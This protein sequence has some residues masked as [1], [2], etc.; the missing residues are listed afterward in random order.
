MNTRR[1]SIKATQFAKPYVYVK[2]LSE[3][4]I[5]LIY[6]NCV[7]NL[8][9]HRYLNLMGFTSTDIREYCKGD[10]DESLVSRIENALKKYQVPNEDFVSE[11][12]GYKIILFWAGETALIS[13]KKSPFMTN[14]AIKLGRS[15]NIYLNPNKKGR[16][17]AYAIPESWWHIKP[18]TDHVA[19]LIK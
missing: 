14:S 8:S 17:R 5:D 19:T 2:D 11:F 12:D 3:S 16:I 15:D 7:G 10:A 9:E 1:S 6:D 18:K 13:V 4:V